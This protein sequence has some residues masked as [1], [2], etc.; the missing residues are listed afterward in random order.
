VELHTAG[1]CVITFPADTRW[2]GLQPKLATDF[3][4]LR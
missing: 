3:A 2:A 1:L 4:L